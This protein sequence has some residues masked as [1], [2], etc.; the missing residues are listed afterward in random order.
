MTNP[1]G[2]RADA[3]DEVSDDEVS[4]DDVSDTSQR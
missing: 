4:D 2:M 1:P 3:D